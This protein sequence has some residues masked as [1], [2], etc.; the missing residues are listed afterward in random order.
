MSLFCNRL[1]H[2]FSEACKMTSADAYRH[3]GLVFSED[4]VTTVIE[5]GKKAGQRSEGH[6]AIHRNPPT[7]N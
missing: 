1:Q 7:Q 6:V 5:S 2:V 4:A 3:T